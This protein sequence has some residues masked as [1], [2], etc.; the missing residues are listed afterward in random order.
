MTSLCSKNKARG[1]AFQA[2]L[3]EL[4]GGINIGTL[5]GEDIM[6]DEFSYEAKTYN[7]KAKTYKGKRWAGDLALAYFD[8][9]SAWSRFIVCKVVS[10]YFPTLYM[11]R[12]HW[13]VQLLEGKLSKEQISESIRECNKSK[14][15][16]D[17]YM[18]QAENNCPDGKLPVVSVHTT[19]DRH[20]QDV[21][22]VRGEYWKSLLESRI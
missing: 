21:V 9:S 16:G 14:F 7:R 1:R 4:S 12:W 18:S 19:G 3:A 2:K 22:L 15:V 20:T 11:L 10:Y 5:G 13:W 6:H 8:D 17:S